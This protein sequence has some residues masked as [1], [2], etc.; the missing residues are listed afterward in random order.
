MAPYYVDNVLVSSSLIRALLVRR[1]FRLAERYLSRAFRISG[2]VLL[3]DVKQPYIRLKDVS[4]PDNGSYQVQ[5]YNRDTLLFS[6]R[7][8]IKQ[9]NASAR[10]VSIYVPNNYNMPLGLP[11]TLQ[12]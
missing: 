8:L 2:R 12:F 3:D 4:C 11:I 10:C 6:A 5:I 9:M 1:E 7:I